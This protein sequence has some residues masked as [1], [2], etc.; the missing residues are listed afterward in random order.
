MGNIWQ[1][2][3][4]GTAAGCIGTGLGGLIISLLRTPKSRTLS[5]VLAFSGG[6]MLAV[7]FQDLIPEAL[8]YGNL[9]VLLY[10]IVLGCGFL[11][12]LDQFIPHIQVSAVGNHSKKTM[13]LIRTSILIGL[14]IALHNLPEGL[15]IGAGYAASE[16]LGIGL[17]LILAL[18][19]APEG[20]AM[21]GPMKAA[22]LSP[23][24]I[25]ATCAAA[26]LPTG[27]GA[28][29]GAYLGSVSEVFLSAALGFAAGAMLYLVF[30]ELI[31][32]AQELDEQNSATFG[33]L[34]GL[35]LGIIFLELI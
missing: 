19:D 35:V 29:I 21:A 12:L 14:G 5:F 3:L 18:H 4:L 31:P 30:D 23:L 10:G 1:A 26:G 17:A 24:R 11:Y 6:I 32:I 25:V 34:T 2:A 20:L 16:S 15:A 33:A 28:L 7:I 13:R 27:L 9:S 8:A 22:G